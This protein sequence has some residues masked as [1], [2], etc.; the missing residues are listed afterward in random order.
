VGARI[1]IGWSEADALVVSNE[2][3]AVAD[4]EARR[5]VEVEGP[6]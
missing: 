1:E 4:A 2:N 3:V 6:A 5:L